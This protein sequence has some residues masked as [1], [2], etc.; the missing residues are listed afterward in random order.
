[1]PLLREAVRPRLNGT[2]KETQSKAKL[3]QT[4]LGR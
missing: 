3:A 4:A 1:M 2:E